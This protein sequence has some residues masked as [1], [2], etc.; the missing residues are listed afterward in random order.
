MNVLSI[1]GLIYKPKLGSLLL[2]F[3]N[4]HALKAC[5]LP[6]PPPLWLRQP[7]SSFAQLDGSFCGPHTGVRR[8]GHGSI[9]LPDNPTCEVDVTVA[10]A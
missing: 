8:P 6:Y 7:V 9:N 5:G 2:L 10:V 4:S 3:P 1:L